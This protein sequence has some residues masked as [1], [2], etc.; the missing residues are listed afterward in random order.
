MG[1]R[2]SLVYH[3]LSYPFMQQDL[4][5]APF[6]VLHSNLF[7]KRWWFWI[8]RIRNEEMTC[9]QIQIHESLTL[10]KKCLPSRELT[11]STWGIG[12]ST[13]NVLAGREYVSSQECRFSVKIL[14]KSKCFVKLEVYSFA[15]ESSWQIPEEQRYLKGLNHLRFQ[16]KKHPS[17]VIGGAQLFVPL[18]W[19]SW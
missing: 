7:P 5:V 18:V 17:E 2:W 9:I 16:A 14:V 15:D 13:S 8:Q 1:F 10:L 11:Y 3:G 19:T 4:E 6:S 12:K